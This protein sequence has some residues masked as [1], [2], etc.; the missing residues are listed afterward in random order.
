MAGGPASSSAV[1]AAER[2]APINTLNIDPVQ[3]NRSGG[4]GFPTRLLADPSTRI[5][6]PRDA[7]QRDGEEGFNG[8]GSLG[9]KHIHQ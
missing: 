2:G 3:Q 9:L 4:T 7:D 8:T 5:P 6:P 1:G